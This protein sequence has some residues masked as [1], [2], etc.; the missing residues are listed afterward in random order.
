MA[1]FAGETD[2]VCAASSLAAGQLLQYLTTTVMSLVLAFVGSLLLTLV[3]L[4]AAPAF[5]VLT[6]PP[7]ARQRTFT[8]SAATVMERAIS[9]IAAVKAFTSFDV[10]HMYVFFHTVLW[11]SAIQRILRRGVMEKDEKKRKGLL[12]SPTLTPLLVLFQDN[13]QARARN[14]RKDDYEV[15]FV[16]EA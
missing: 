16:D 8:T 3:I 14:T 10:F 4:S 1:K 7:L 2:E 5:K 11:P 12:M 9:T 6:G 15:L 13:R